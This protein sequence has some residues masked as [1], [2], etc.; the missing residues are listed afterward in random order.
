M[1]AIF[2]RTFPE[3]ETFST[4]PVGVVRTV[5]GG[6]LGGG[7]GGGLTTVV[8]VVGGGLTTV[9]VAVGGGLT[10]DVVAV[11]DGLTTDVAVGSGLT[12]VCVFGLELKPDDGGSDLEFEP[13][14]ENWLPDEGVAGRC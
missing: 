13:C 14:D 2:S 8:V 9:V 7:G 6:G 4:V 12:G 11:G 5:R 10:T 3:G 1:L